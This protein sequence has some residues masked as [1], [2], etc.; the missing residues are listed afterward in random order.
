MCKEAQQRPAVFFMFTG[1]IVLVRAKVLSEQLRRMEKD[2]SMVGLF[3]PV[4]TI[5]QNRMMD[6]GDIAGRAGGAEGVIGQRN[7]QAK[8]PYPDE[9]LESCIGQR[10]RGKSFRQKRQSVLFNFS[11]LFYS[12]NFREETFY[13]K[14]D[15]II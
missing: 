5:L 7:S 12:L 9:S 1:T 6:L 13:G 15:S 8:G 10:R 3:R 11:A 4:L 14:K 2:A